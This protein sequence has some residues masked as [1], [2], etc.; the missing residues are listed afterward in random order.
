M[1]VFALI[2]ILSSFIS[3]VQA[4]TF[5]SS[6]D[7][8][9]DFLRVDQA[10]QLSMSAPE[11]GQIQANFHIADG[12]YLY[13]R[14][15]LLSGEGAKHLYFA[16][17]PDGESHTDAYFGDVT[18]FRNELSLPIYYD[19]NLAAGTH[20]EA[21]LM[22]QGC[23]DRGLC[24]PP[25]PAV[26]SFQVPALDSATQA[27]LQNQ[28]HS[29]ADNSNTNQ[30]AQIEI[31]PSQANLVFDTLTNSSLWVGLASVFGLGLL[32]SLTP[33]VLPMVP[34]VSAIV[35]GAKASKLRALFYTLLYI[36]GMALTY[37]GIG[38]LVAAFGASFNL[39]AQLQNPIVLGTSAV[40][41]VI[42]ALFMFGVFTLNMPSFLQPNVSYEQ[43]E[44][45][46]WKSG[47]GSFVA[48]IF[49]T[50]VVSPCV[51]APLA[52]ILLFVSTQNE[53]FYGALMLFIL[54]LGM[55]IPLLLVGLFGPRIL[56]KNGEWLND[57][58]QLM[59]FGLLAVSAWLVSSWLPIFYGN[60]IW[61]L[62]ALLVSSYF[63]HRIFS[64]QSH[65]VRWFI[66][67]TGLLFAILQTQSSWPQSGSG[68]P[69]QVGSVNQETETNGLFEAKINSLGELNQLIAQDNSAPIMLDFYADW[70]I[71]CKI[72]EKE[73][74]S[75]QDVSQ[76]LQ[77]VRL[78]KVDVTAN[79]QANRDFLTKFNIYGPPSI[80][81][82]DNEG[83][84]L[85]DLSLI[86]EPT[87]EQ[88]MSRL[89]YLSQV[90]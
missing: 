26:I 3:Q 35:V 2:I 51:S 54:A 47:F 61:A 59:G 38:F 1:R 46:W 29:L 12:Y 36:L 89:T 9:P 28:S 15:F 14:Q 21:T 44:K 72:L 69:Q 8:Q 10:F 52:G 16:P 5:G 67:L 56:P 84:E 48:G 66:A 27:L 37:A 86:G 41:F 6:F 18:I 57:I 50:L 78:I 70:C 85:P 73:V 32:L 81:F 63:F 22:F 68:Q 65:P 17:F 82:L 80:I 79:S 24:Y 77:Q 4:F 30:T 33:C 23:A 60:L 75:Q 25:E 53:P 88:I 11:R 71:S 43:N 7:Q 45:S 42:L 19:I 40:M 39:Q 58:K 13:K 34:I 90:L 55:S 76:A 64:S 87:K 20:I 74:F 31:A 83:Q 62:L 49:S